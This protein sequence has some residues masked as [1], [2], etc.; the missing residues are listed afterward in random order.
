DSYY[1]GISWTQKQVDL[2]PYVGS[3][4]RVRFYQ[5]ESSAGYDG[6]YIDDVRILE[7]PCARVDYCILESPAAT[8]TSPGIPTEEIYALVRESGVTD[9]PGQGGGIHAEI[10]VVLLPR[11]GPSPWDDTW[12]WYPTTYH[13]D[14]DS[15]DRYVGTLTVDSGGIYAYVFRFRLEGE[16]VWSYADLDGNDL[17]VGGLNGYSWEQAGQLV[18]TGH[19]DIDVSPT[20]F[21]WSLA[22]GDSTTSVLRI[23]NTGTGDLSFEI[24]ES[25][26]LRVD[27][28]EARGSRWDIAWLSVE[29]TNGIV[30]PGDSADV[31]VL[32]KAVDCT[33]GVNEAYLVVLSNDPDESPIV[34]GASLDVATG[35]PE[36]NTVPS[37]FALAQSVPNPFSRETEIQYGLPR[38]CDVKLEIFDVAG[39][40]VDVIVDSRESAGSR[41]VRW[42]AAGLPSG[43][44]FYRLQAG[45]FMA[46]RRMVLIR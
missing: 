30:A 26:H 27:A 14:Q 29:T 41:I 46:T 6:W 31:T 23:S 34:I 44:Y 2:S 21:L 15:L 45:E 33:L 10:G 5:Y 39:R 43:I 20:S 25:P 9:A 12:S 7:G 32:A 24:F 3:M 42:E 38:S 19:C 8:T 35:V 40:R 36:D 28:R 13:S 16:D 17:G 18:V 1:G 11:S 37:R 4:V 22:P